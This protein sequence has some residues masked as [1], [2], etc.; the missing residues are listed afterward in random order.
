MRSQIV[1]PADWKLLWERTI[2]RA[3]APARQIGRAIGRH[4]RKSDEIR[5]DGDI[6]VHRLGVRA[7]AVCRIDQRLSDLAVDAG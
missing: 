1:P 2:G 4:R 5:L 6:A 7:D 3:A